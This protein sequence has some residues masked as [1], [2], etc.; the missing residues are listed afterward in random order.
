[1]ISLS[2]RG[3]GSGLYVQSRSIRI[4]IHDVRDSGFF[5]ATQVQ[6]AP[7][8]SSR[9]QILSKESLPKAAHLYAFE[10]SVT[11]REYPSDGITDQELETRTAHAGGKGNISG[12]CL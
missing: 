1:M 4:D 10:V 8:L 2:V 12:V 5:M 3:E 9:E 11:M 6:S 7:Q